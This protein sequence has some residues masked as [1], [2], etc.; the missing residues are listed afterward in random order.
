M[1]RFAAIWDIGA[2]GG[3][4]VFAGWVVAG[5]A[6]FGSPGIENTVSADRGRCNV[7]VDAE[8]MNAPQ[9]TAI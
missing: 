5:L 6:G 9:A 2:F 4:V 3:T 1:I 8:P 7:A